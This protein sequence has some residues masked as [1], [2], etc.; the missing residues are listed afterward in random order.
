MTKNGANARGQA[1]PVTND[2][3]EGE[4]A[5]PPTP[6]LA[7]ARARPGRPRRPRA[8]RRRCHRPSKPKVTPLVVPVITKVEPLLWRATQHAAQHRSVSRGCRCPR[9]DRSY[10]AR[11]R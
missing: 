2:R 5:D 9:G 10:R 4:G 11:V 1:G 3:A 7:P 6:E 8:L